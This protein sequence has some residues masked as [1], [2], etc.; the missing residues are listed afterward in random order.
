MQPITVDT[1][2]IDSFFKEWNDSK[3]Q[4][5][6]YKLT[7]NLELFHQIYIDKN[8]GKSK[9]LN[10]FREIRNSINDHNVKKIFDDL[11]GPR[12][13]KYIP[14]NINPD[15]DPIL[16]VTRHT[17]DKIGLSKVRQVINELNFYDLPH[18]NSVEFGPDNYLYRIPKNITIQP[19]QEFSNFKLFEPYI[20]DAKK[21]EFCDLFLFKN[22]QYEDDAEFLFSLLN[23]CRNLEYIEIHCEPN[24]INIRQI[25]VK[26]R[27]KK[28]FGKNIFT[29]FKKYNPPT[30]DINH[31][32]FII[33]DTD[34]ISIRF[35]SSFNNFR[36]VSKNR[37]KVVDSFLIEISRGRKY[38]D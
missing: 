6:F 17:P 9:W 11:I 32:R 22:P 16:E 27:L 8:N 35:S 2:I 23:V 7:E 21:I 25:E 29:E 20:R 19:G 18:F 34:R 1:E 36:I 24:K 30:R 13:I 33:I 3:L 37:F 12:N 15:N 14:I 5:E 10:K 31:D 38:F 26:S 4:R 28:E